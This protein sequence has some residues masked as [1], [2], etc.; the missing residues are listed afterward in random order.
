MIFKILVLERGIALHTD[1]VF[2][3]DNQPKTHTIIVRSVV[4]QFFFDIN[5]F[6]KYVKPL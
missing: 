6:K 2:F 4:L 5:N 3:K 1:I